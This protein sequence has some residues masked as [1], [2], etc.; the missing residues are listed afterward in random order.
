MIKNSIVEGKMDDLLEDILTNKKDI[1]KS[2]DNIIYQITTTYNQKNNDYE[3]ISTIDLE[4]CEDELK[5]IYNLSKNDTLII[6]KYDYKIPD[7]LIPIIG[8]ELFHPIT[9]E[10]LDL[11]YCEKNK[12]K[13]DLI[14]PVKINESELYRHNPNDTYYKD[15]CNTDSN[16]KS[17]D[18]TLYD[19]KNIYN[20]KNLALCANNCEFEDY[21]NNTKKVKCICEPH[22][23]NSLIN[24]DNIINKKKLLNNFKDIHST[25]NL[26]IIKCYKNF[27]SFKGLKSNIGSYIL[28]SI[29][30]IDFIGAIIFTF[31][32]YKILMKK[33]N[34][35]VNNSDGKNNVNNININNPIKKGQRVIK[36]NKVINTKDNIDESNLNNNPN[37]KNTNTNN[38]NNE[39]SVNKSK[40]RRKK[41]KK[42]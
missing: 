38:I 33:L 25:T 6:V 7:L 35:I 15:K 5:K 32:E 40:I 26:D 19:K 14:I 2:D 1:V 18:I 9:K 20:E 39:K 27:L 11:N 41:E 29:I 13:I 42:F 28:L 3:N 21:D 16:N 34:D 24:L 10:V 31:V 12:T 22:Y 23:N 37:D 17:F 4:G 30:L 36:I 8:Y